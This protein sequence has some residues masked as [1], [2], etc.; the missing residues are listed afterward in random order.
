[1]NSQYKYRNVTSLKAIKLKTNE[2]IQAKKP[3]IIPVM[4]ETIKHK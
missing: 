1:M 3:Q 2:I 4:N